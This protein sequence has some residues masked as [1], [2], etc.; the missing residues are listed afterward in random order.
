MTTTKKRRTTVDASAPKGTASAAKLREE[1]A[2][3]AERYSFL[4]KKLGG[5]RHHV[6]TNEQL[7]AADVIRLID[8]VI[9][10]S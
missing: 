2:Q 7:T 8:N 10:A 4:Q 9:E 3:L 5:L 6:A 1:N